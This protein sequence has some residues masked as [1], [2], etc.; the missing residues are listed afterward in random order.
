MT[1]KGASLYDENGQLIAPTRLGNGSSVISPAPSQGNM[2]LSTAYF[3]MVVPIDKNSAENKKFELQIS[4]TDM[5]VPYKDGQG[6]E[7]T[8]TLQTNTK[9]D[10]IIRS[11]ET[12]ANGTYGLY[13]Y[14]AEADQK[15]GFW[16]ENLSSNKSGMGLDAYT[17]KDST[18]QV[19][20]C[21]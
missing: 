13:H 5:K 2:Y 14:Y 17:L 20:R 4:D 15:D 10:N 18:V 9:N 3:Q 16:G 8:A 19:V 12:F 21:V 6:N 1:V 7:K 11:Y